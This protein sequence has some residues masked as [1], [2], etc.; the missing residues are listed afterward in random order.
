MS[1]SINNLDIYRESM[2]LADVIWDLVCKWEDL[3]KNTIGNQFVRATDSISANIAEGHGRYH[4]KENQKFCYYARGSLVET[5]TWPEK[6]ATRQLI[7]KKSSARALQ[8]SRIT[9]QTP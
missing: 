9:P 3:A 1:A 5:Q 6:S 2:R 7:E 4:Y 8:R